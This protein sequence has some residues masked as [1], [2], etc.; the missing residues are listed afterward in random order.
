M[1]L[2]RVKV[3]EMMRLA[4]SPT[5]EQ[6]KGARHAR[7]YGHPVGDQRRGIV[8]QAFALEDRDQAAGQSQPRCDAGCSYRVRRGDNRSQR[9]R[10]RPRH[11]LDQPV[12]DHGDRDRGREDETDRQ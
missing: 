4:I 12:R 2:A 3:K 6:G 1:S 11:A 9:E 7:R 5:V 8:D 10:G